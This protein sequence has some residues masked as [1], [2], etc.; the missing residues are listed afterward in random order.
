MTRENTEAKAFAKRLRDLM[1][2]RGHVSPGAHS[3]V[4]VSAIAHAVGIS[5]E[6]ARRYAEG[7]AIPRPAKLAALARWLGVSPSA[8]A[9]GTTTTTTIDER[10]LEQCLR[11]VREAQERAGVRLQPD[12]A[13]HLVAILYGEAASG[14]LPEPRALDLLIKAS[15]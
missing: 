7:L 14:S 15:T 6:M 5:Y 13:A 8:L 2:A 11:A 9:Y 12:R 10:V 1:R 4:D 3:G